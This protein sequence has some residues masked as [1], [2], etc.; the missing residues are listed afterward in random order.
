MS[1]FDIYW[2]KL[3]KLMDLMKPG[4]VLV[5]PHPPV[6]FLFSLQCFF[7]PF[8]MKTRIFSYSN[9]ATHPFNP[10]GEL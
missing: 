10:T 2:A 7:S 6:D 4:G 3:R 5:P 9:D 1:W 8:T